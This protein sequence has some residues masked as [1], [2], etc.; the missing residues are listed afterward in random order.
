MKKKFCFFIALFFIVGSAIGYLFAVNIMPEISTSD[1][2]AVFASDLDNVIFHDG[3]ELRIINLQKLLQTK[4][5]P[6]DNNEDPGS[7]PSEDYFGVLGAIHY[8]LKEMEITA[9]DEII[10]VIE[11]PHD[12]LKPDG[13]DTYIACNTE[14]V[15]QVKDELYYF[16]TPPGTTPLFII[17][18]YKNGFFIEGGGVFGIHLSELENEFKPV[19]KMNAPN[20]NTIAFTSNYNEQNKKTTNDFFC[21]T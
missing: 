11:Q 16:S 9:T 18:I 21:L 2:D 4:S 1:L 8:P 14:V 6:I 13:F 15:K 3:P 17:S 20:S 7:N 19:N 10:I 12:E 5:V